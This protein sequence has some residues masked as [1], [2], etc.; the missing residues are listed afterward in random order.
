MM[1][2]LNQKKTKNIFYQ[3]LSKNYF[4][5]EGNLLKKFKII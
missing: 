5:K 2:I 3:Q 4:F 1:G